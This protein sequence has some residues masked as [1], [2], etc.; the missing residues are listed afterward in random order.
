MKK[1]NMIGPFVV[2]APF[3]TE[4]AFKNGL[5][6]LGYE[7]NAIDPNVEDLDKID[8]KAVTVVFKSVLGKQ[9][10]LKKLNRNSVI[11]YQPDDM[12]FPHVR[13]MALEMLPFCEH[14]LSFDESSAKLAQNLG[15]K[16]CKK[17]LVVADPAVYYR[18]Y[19]ESVCDTKVETRHS[20]PIDVCMVASLG[21]PVSH[22][23]RRRLSQISHELGREH[24]WNVQIH[25]GIR[26]PKIINKMYNQ[27]K[28]VINHAT[29]VGQEFGSGFGFQCRH[30]EVALTNTAYLTN[31]IIGEKG[32]PFCEFSTEK[33]FRFWLEELVFDETTRNNFADNGF[34]WVNEKHLP[35]H[36]AQELVDY[37]KEVVC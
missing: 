33:E 35:H 31:T 3:G 37:I 23:S 15:Y 36:R 8:E 34:E 13:E 2:N 29:D 19:T 20:R 1:I 12:R 16:N 32:Q 11:L 6:Q 10:Q 9:E 5:E 7:V 17:L 22:T 27:S 21:D 30:F 18:K 24:G 14:F 26:D 25:E 4:I 28:V